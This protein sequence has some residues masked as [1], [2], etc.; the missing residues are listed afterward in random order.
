MTALGVGKGYANTLSSRIQVEQVPI[1]L[2]NLP[3]AFRGFKIAQLSD[4]H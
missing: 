2:K 4:L 3:E 1:R